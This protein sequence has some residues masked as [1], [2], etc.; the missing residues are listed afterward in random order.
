ML[1]AQETNVLI[2]EQHRSQVQEGNDRVL[3]NMRTS[4][5]TGHEQDSASA[6]SMATQLESDH[7]D[8]TGDHRDTTGDHRDPT[9]DHR[10]P[11]SDHRDTT[12]KRTAV[13][14]QFDGVFHDR[15]NDQ[16][17][18][19]EDIR[20]Q[21]LIN[22]VMKYQQAIADL[23]FRIKYTLDQIKH[24]MYTK[25]CSVFK[26]SKLLLSLHYLQNSLSQY[27]YRLHPNKNEISKAG[28]YTK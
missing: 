28:A 21:Y 26:L 9:G 16:V 15:Q 23:Q 5:K 25:H 8:T 22:T 19:E 4:G 20:R 1:Q 6:W 14:E 10:D 2:D 17:E 24:H 27:N 12:E 3:D 11:T 13:S 18:K 7:R